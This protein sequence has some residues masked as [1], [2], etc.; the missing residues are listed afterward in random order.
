VSKRTDNFYNRF[1]FFYPLVDIFLKPQKR[2]LFQEINN[3]PYGQLLEI[4]V[5]NGKHLPLYQTHK[6][7]GID[8]SSSMLKIAGKH[9]GDNISLLRMNGELL[10]FPDKSFD[11]VVLSH[12]ITV[13][14]DPERLL[15][16]TNRVLKADGRVF[17]LNHFT[18]DNWLKYIDRSF[19]VVAKIFHFQS[20]FYI[21]RLAAMKSFRLLKEIDFGPVAYFKLLI[22][23][24][25]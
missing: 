22:L 25:A 19:Q 21:D 1:S 13:V 10:Q 23:S 7:T 9:K 15:E 14:D 2:R 16:E 24:K 4:G 6:I 17:I 12:V 20:V 8:T 18:P 3:L 5:G 11:Y